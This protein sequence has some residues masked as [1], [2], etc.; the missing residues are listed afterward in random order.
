MLV[1]FQNLQIYIYIYKTPINPST[2]EICPGEYLNAI[3]HLKKK[4]S[5]KIY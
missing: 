2:Q 5:L 1:K 4:T 3:I